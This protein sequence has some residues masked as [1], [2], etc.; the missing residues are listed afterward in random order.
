M[1][2]P[3]LV[4]AGGRGERFKGGE[5][6]LAMCMGRPL[7]EHVL[8]S[9][10][11]AKRISTIHVVTSPWTR[12]TEEHLTGK[13]GVLRAPGKSYVEDMVHAL[14]T[15]GLGPTL[16]TAADLPLIN[17]GDVDNVVSVYLNQREPA[18]AVMVPI[19]LFRSLGLTP[20]I[21]YED[22]VPAGINVVDGK[23]LE[24]PQK[25]LVV[26]NHRFAV[27]VNTKEDLLR[28]NRKAF[29]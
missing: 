2:L 15:L 6:P 8:M 13:W 22:L 5:K 26:D 14:K 10:E 23:N 29:K 4:M 21:V 24:G 7:V 19:S 20:T 17:P 18:L 1:R 11:K 9:L 28:L 12:R 27:N 3:A 16:V 25:I